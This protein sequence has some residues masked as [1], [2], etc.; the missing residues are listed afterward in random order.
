MHSDGK[1]RMIRVYYYSKKDGFLEHDD[2]DDGAEW[3]VGENGNL[4]IWKTDNS[5]LAEYA[6]M[7]WSRVMKVEK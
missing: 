6:G 5:N 1:T 4:Q 2:Y 7:D 3:E